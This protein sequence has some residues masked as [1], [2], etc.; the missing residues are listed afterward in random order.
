MKEN[1]TSLK[2]VFLP[3]VSLNWY[4]ITLDL[5]SYVYFLTSVLCQIMCS[6]FVVSWISKMPWLIYKE[7]FTWKLTHSP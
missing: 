7:N 2:S 4:L 3:L 1:K 6:G 5:I